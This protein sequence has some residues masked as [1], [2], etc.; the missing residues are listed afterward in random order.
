MVARCRQ[1][2]IQDPIAPLSY[3]ESRMIHPQ[4]TDDLS[5]FN[6]EGYVPPLD[7]G[8]DGF[9]PLPAAAAETEGP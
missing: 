5:G 1:H 9:S 2:Q 8:L 3:E 4:R 7:E 6:R